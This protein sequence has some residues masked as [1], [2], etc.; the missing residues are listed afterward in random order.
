MGGL[1]DSKGYG[2][3]K[4]QLA[5]QGDLRPDSQAA[6]EPSSPTV[7]RCRSRSCGCGQHRRR[8]RPGRP[9]RPRDWAGRILFA[10]DGRPRTLGQ[11][12]GL[13]GVSRDE[14]GFLAALAGLLVQGARPGAAWVFTASG[15]RSPRLVRVFN[16]P[17]KK[18]AAAKF[19]VTGAVL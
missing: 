2:H 10:I 1:Y 4:T 16:R 12:R 14:R 6:S 11:L 9:V 15:Q 19:R 3:M 13:A 17:R 5:S 18:D 7:Y 8:A